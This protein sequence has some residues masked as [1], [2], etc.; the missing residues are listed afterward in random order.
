MSNRYSRV[1]AL[2]LLGCAV[3]LTGCGDGQVEVKLPTASAPR[4][5]LKT[6]TLHMLADGR[7]RGTDATIDLAAAMKTLG[8]A[9]TTQVILC[10]H[11]AQFEQVSQAYATIRKAGYERSTMAV[12]DSTDCKS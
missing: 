2:A 12:G 1:F 7:F 11:G 4:P 9:A 5:A 8:P 3:A 10:A 6:Q